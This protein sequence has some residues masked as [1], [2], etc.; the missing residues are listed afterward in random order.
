MA[1]QLQPKVG[2]KRHRVTLDE[3]ERM[4]EAGVFE[5]EARIELIRGEIVD[6]PAPG[7]EH[8]NGV[9]RL[10]HFLYAKVL[11]QAILSPQG[12]AIRLPET[13]SQPQ[14]DLAVLKWR[15]DLYSGKRPTVEDVLLLV[16]VSWS[17]LPYDRK[18]KLSLYAEA[19]IPEYWIINL[20][21]KVVEVYSQPCNGKYE[22]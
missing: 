18:T 12:N 13:V 2:I 16:E 21:E 17:S 7:P 14:P 9:L 10:H 22:S 3:Y 15:D 8:D 6:M 20:V 5:P 4:C 19:G 1:L 11:G